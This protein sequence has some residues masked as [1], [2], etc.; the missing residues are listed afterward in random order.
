MQER[1]PFS[2]Q[3]GQVRL[4]KDAAGQGPNAEDSLEAF[5]QSLLEMQCEMISATGAAI[6]QPNGEK[7]I[8][9]INVHPPKASNSAPPGWLARAAAKLRSGD[10]PTSP[11]CQPQSDQASGDLQ[12]PEAFFLILPLP[13]SDHQ[14]AVA[15]YTTPVVSRHEA[16]YM[17]RCLNASLGHLQSYFTRRTLKQRERDIQGLTNILQ[18]Q[19]RTNDSHNFL[20][21]AM[22][23]CNELTT[24]YSL[25]R[26]SLGIQVGRDVKVTAMS[27]T[28]HIN[29]R[30]NLV[31][32]LEAAMEECFDQDM[33]ILFPCPDHTPIA[34]R[35]TQRLSQEFG[36]ATVCSV[37]IRRL[38]EVR[39]VVTLERDPDSQFTLE[40]L[41]ELRILIDL[42]STRLLE[43]YD[44][45]RWFGARWAAKA[46]RGLQVILGPQY[47]WIKLAAVI[48]ISAILFMIFVKGPDRITADFSIEA[49]ERQIIPAPFDGFIQQVHVEPGDDIQAGQTVLATMDASELQAQLAELQAELVMHLKEGDVARQEGKESQVQIAEARADRA[50]SRIQSVL[51]KIEQSQLMSA[52]GG[53]VL[54]GDLKDRLGAPVS[55]G[56]VLFEVAP[57]QALRAELYV[58]DSR[59]GELHVG[60]NGEMATASHPDDSIGFV[61]ESI[62]PVAEVID[63]ANVFRVKVKLEQQPGWVRPGVEGIAKI[64]VGRKPYGVLWTRDA[65]NWIR[66]QLW[67]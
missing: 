66:M 44:E 48:I 36:P 52:L 47:T 8:A 31:Q 5:L 43:R 28:E 34:T 35:M 57:H 46:R 14:Q 59:I 33:E 30:M 67:I 37:P 15:V 3:S 24:R 27:Q 45:D 51:L 55:R 2:A 56:D 26:A 20:T 39:G 19:H 49:V 18:L 22:A 60:Q 50:R 10:W 16:M 54:V 41:R 53:I 9:V 23:L 62:Y 11:T 13:L 61:V 21:S 1:P 12:S 65:W 25:E 17:L 32:R 42:A 58:P 6:L 63:Q 7:D 40:E 64:T 38:G 29:R 4:D